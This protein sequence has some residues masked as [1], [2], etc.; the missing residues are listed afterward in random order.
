MC[1]GRFFVCECATA[2]MYDWQFPGSRPSS[3]DGSVFSIAEAC[4][5]LDLCSKPL[6]D[7]SLVITGGNELQSKRCDVKTGRFCY[8]YTL[9][10]LIVEMRETLRYCYMYICG[11]G[12][13][14][15][16]KIVAGTFNLPCVLALA[17]GV[18]CVAVVSFTLVTG[19]EI[20]FS[21]R[22]CSQWNTLLSKSLYHLARYTV[23]LFK[24]LDFWDF[25]VCLLLVFWHPQYGLICCRALGRCKRC[26]ER[27]IQHHREARLLSERSRYRTGHTSHYFWLRSYVCPLWW[28]IWCLCVRNWFWMSKS[29]WNL[30]VENWFPIYVLWWLVGR[31]FSKRCAQPR[32]V[33]I[34]GCDK[35]RKFF[36]ATSVHLHVTAFISTKNWGSI[37]QRYCL[38]RLFVGLLQRLFCVEV[39]R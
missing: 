11:I 5:N 12:F 26:V 31:V 3:V 4:R 38:N 8:W 6:T 35:P 2:Q 15:W 17:L 16:L 27:N 28:G 19:I 37:R 24:S 1:T 21:D 36:E 9:L 39:V 29:N 30:Y 25:L 32:S 18:Y 10:W 33:G 13:G 14:F 34:S 20:S 23:P 7:R 22:I